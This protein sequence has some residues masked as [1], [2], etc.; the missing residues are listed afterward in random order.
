MERPTSASSSLMSFRRRFL[1]TTSVTICLVL[2]L[3]LSR[4]ASWWGERKGYNRIETDSL[5]SHS[6][7]S[8]KAHQLFVLE[9]LL[10][11]LELLLLQ[12]F[13]EVIDCLRRWRKY[14]TG[15]QAGESKIAKFY[16][17]RQSSTIKPKYLDTAALRS[18]PTRFFFASASATR[19]AMFVSRS[20]TTWMRPVACL[21][22]SWKLQDQ[23]CFAR[24]FRKI[25]SQNTF[26]PDFLCSRSLCLARLKPL[27]HFGR[28]RG[29][30]DSGLCRLGEDAFNFLWV[31]LKQG[32]I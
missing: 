8:F 2:C 31:M 9:L 15:S 1:V 13:D 19:G 26:S 23:D 12:L 3:Y 6:Q 16:Y 17:C 28:P 25:V 32:F 14:Y 7:L 20:W 30:Q 22:S 11:H 4:D 5:H 21:T 24:L 27:G 18:G 29:L 10:L